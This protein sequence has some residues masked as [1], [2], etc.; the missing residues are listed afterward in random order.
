VLLAGRRRWLHDS[1]GFL[2]RGAQGAGGP[3]VAVV[4]HAVCSVFLVVAASDEHRP[5]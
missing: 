5:E 1:G 4:W 2:G 3:L